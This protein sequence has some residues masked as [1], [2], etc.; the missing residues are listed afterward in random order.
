M[1]YLAWA[2]IYL[3]VYDI[4]S[5]L[6]LQYAETLLRIIGQHEHSL[7]IRQH[8]TFLVGNKNDLERYRYEVEYL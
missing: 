4:T 7:C 5:Q 2:D 8:V 6:S 1:R 3:V